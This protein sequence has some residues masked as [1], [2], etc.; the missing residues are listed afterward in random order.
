VACVE[1]GTEGCQ[2]GIWQVN[3]TGSFI[4]VMRSGVSAKA[5]LMKDYTLEFDVRIERG[6]FEWV[7]VRQSLSLRCTYG[8]QRLYCVSGVYNWWRCTVWISGV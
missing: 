8:L 1:K 3:Q 5:A 4:R 7:V 6:G 2:Q